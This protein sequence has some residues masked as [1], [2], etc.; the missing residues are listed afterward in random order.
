MNTW[1]ECLAL[2]GHGFS[3]AGSGFGICWALAPEGVFQTELKNVSPA[4]KA[5]F[6]LHGLRHGLSRALSKLRVLL[7]VLR[8]R[9]KNERNAP[10]ARPFYAECREIWDSI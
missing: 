6:M 5:E 10:I 2:R 9:E 3:R 1:T 4:A 8:T 7:Q